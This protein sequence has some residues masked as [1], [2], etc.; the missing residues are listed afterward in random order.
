LFQPFYIRR[1]KVNPNDE[2][3]KVNFVDQNGDKWE[4]FPVLHTKFKDWLNISYTVDQVEMFLNNKEALQK[5]FEQSPWYKSTANDIDWLTRVKIQSII[6]K[7]TT[8]SISSTINLPNNVSKHDVALIYQKSFDAGLKGVTIYRDGCRTGVLVS[9]TSNEKSKSFEYKDAPKRPDTLECDVHIS[10]SKGIEYCII[11]GLYDNKPY[12]I[13]CMPNT[14]NLSYKESYKG[15][16]I[17]VKSKNYKLIIENLISIDNINFDMSDEQVA[18]TRLASTSLRHGANIKFVME[19]LN[20]CNGEMFSFTKS[21]G[22]VL[23]KYISEGE[24]S[25]IKCNDCGSSNVIYEEG[26]SKC[27]DCGSSKCS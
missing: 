12:E 7:Y 15:E 22:R 19:Q 16:L 5:A 18:I 17:K 2:N 8:H 20:K 11:I 23:K 27:L 13:F 14:Y 4:E 9:E 26:C 24:K 6:Q 21:L 10:K 3:S 1:K 25:T